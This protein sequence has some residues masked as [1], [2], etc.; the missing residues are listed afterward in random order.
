MQII[1][2][3]KSVYQNDHS[4]SDSDVLVYEMMVNFK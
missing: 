3:L 2:D 1:P 4:F